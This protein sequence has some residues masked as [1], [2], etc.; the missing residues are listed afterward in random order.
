MG[1]DYGHREPVDHVCQ[2]PFKR[3]KNTKLL[4]SDALPLP[5]GLT[6]KVFFVLFFTAS[7][8]LMRR[9]REKIRISCPLHM[10]SFWEIV[11]IVAQLASF[12]YLL[13]F[14]GIAYVQNFISKSP[15]E[16]WDSDEEGEAFVDA[17]KPLRVTK[18]PQVQ[19]L[20]PRLRASRLHVEVPAK[21]QVETAPK[22]HTQL[23]IQSLAA[24]SD[25]DIACAVSNGEV[26]CHSLEVELGDCDRAASV[27]RRAVELMTG[28]SLNGLPLAGFDYS[29]VIG[30]CCEM[31]IGYVQVPVGVAGPLLLDGVEFMVPFATTEG[32]LIASANR[33]CKAIRLSGGATSIVLKD[34]MTRAPVVRFASAQRAAE[35]KFFV[36]DPANF[37]TLSDAFQSTS[38]YGR[39]LDIQCAVAGRNLYMRFVCSTGDA[40]GMN[41]VTKGVE[42]ILNA[43]KQDFPDMDVVSISGN[44]CSDKK[45]TAVNWIQGRGK[46]VVC[47]ALIREEVVSEV[48]KTTVASLVELNMIKNLTGSAVAGALGGFNAHVANIVTAVFIATGQDPAQ[49]IESSQ[50]ITLVEAA[51]GGRDLHV[52]V[53]MPCIEVGTTG[54]GTKL[55]SQAA[56]L[57]LLG[58]NGPNE[59]SPG[60]NAQGL[61]RIVAGAVLAGELSLLAA[62]AKGEL[63]KSHMK[64][65]RSS[66]DMQVDLI[67]DIIHKR[68]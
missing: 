36:E 47:E 1:L 32:T 50:C 16:A 12:I 23:K 55:A 34:G 53:T 67:S 22:H 40:M 59:A 24:N 25:E 48:F 26:S 7:I 35:L 3:G 54:G 21:Q 18:L 11:A 58:V 43:L 4:A 8:F 19:A 68:Q 15:D 41:M 44:Y 5:V 49:N 66:R 57:N 9:W 63:V 56:C 33:G 64:Y 42:K 14:F 27:R 30:Q 6:N 39:L 28:R 46:S 10:L 17:P 13:G 61:A 60:A 52:S 31:A 29:S 51:N 37:Q 38:R 2:K 20:P 65:N 62:Q 45:A